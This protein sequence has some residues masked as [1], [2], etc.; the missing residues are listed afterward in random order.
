MKKCNCEWCDRTEENWKWFYR[1]DNKWYCGKHYYQ[2]KDKGFLI[3]NETNVLNVAINDMYRGWIHE[4]ELN[5]RIYNVWYSMLS[6]CYS[7]AFL[8]RKP[9]YKKCYVCERWLRLSNFIEDISKIE[10]YELWVNN[11]N[12]GIA[13]DKDIKSSNK[14]VCYCL[15]ECKFVTNKDN[16]EQSSKHKNL[17]VAQYDKYGNL[18]KVYVSTREA[19]RI[20]DI[21]HSSISYCCKFWEMDCDKE[22]W[23]KTHKRKPSKTAGG[24]IW[25]YHKK[26]DENE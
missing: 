26:G 1:F 24:F 19:E 16:A 23:N 8:K 15:N 22:K 25:K 5:T 14:N 17:S 10:N 21:S 6:R 4:N 20:T 18:I 11:P 9:F 2:L 13:L 3:T 12:Q 7:E